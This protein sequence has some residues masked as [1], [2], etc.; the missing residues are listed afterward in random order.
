MSRRSITNRPNGF[1]LLEV[2][3]AIALMLALL[4]SMFAFTFNMLTSRARAL[5]YSQKQLAAT[6]LI[7]RVESDLMTCLVGDRRIG[8]GVKGDES[9]L[10]ILS[11]AVAASLALN[12]TSDPAV[13]GDLQQSLYRFRKQTG[14]VEA[15]RGPVTGSHLPSQ[16]YQQVGGA[17]FKVRFRFH[18]GNAWLDS[19]DSNSAGQLP[20]AVEIAVWFRPW[21]GEEMPSEENEFV[22][23]D[24][25]TFDEIDTFDE[26]EYAEISDMDLFSEPKPDRIRVIFI[27]DADVDEDSN[28]ETS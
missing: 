5:E 22:E 8:A 18:D 6:T 1:T 13:L 9:S 14:M 20:V 21:L 11:R 25:L 17:L 10:Q 4:G 12:G 23:D 2:L 28:G 3:I 7:E 19:F 24:R 16:Q 27:P 15:S 26:R